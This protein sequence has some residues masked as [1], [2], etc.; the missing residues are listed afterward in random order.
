MPTQRY[1]APARGA[2]RTDANT[3]EAKAAAKAAAKVEKKKADDQRRAAA[4]SGGNT[5][6]LMD[7][8]TSSSERGL[9]GEGGLCQLAATAVDGRGGKPLSGAPDFNEL[10]KPRAGSSWSA[11]NPHSITALTVADKQP[12]S[13]VWNAFVEWCEKL[14]GD[15]AL[16]A[17]NGASCDFDWVHE[18]VSGGAVLALARGHVR[19]G[20]IAYTQHA[21]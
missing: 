16:V 10:V 19:I 9:Y 18:I 14:P 3:E 4:L 5:Y 11:Y 8:E 1:T 21:V 17:W 6:V 12:V 7:V 15:V 20:G 2:A 13:V